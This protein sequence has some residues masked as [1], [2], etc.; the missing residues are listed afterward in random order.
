VLPSHFEPWGLVINEAM[1]AGKPVIVS[2]FVGAA[3][4]LVQTGRNGWIFE[5]GNVPAL[6]HCL[7]QAITRPDLTA[8][9]KRGLE[10][11]SR[12]DYNADLAGFQA[13]LT[14]V[15]ARQKHA[16]CVTT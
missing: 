11:I 3:P 6:A 15:C 5:H 13:A 8:M 2:D 1:N 7:Q 4:D 9:G 16:E 10:I 14:A 12:W